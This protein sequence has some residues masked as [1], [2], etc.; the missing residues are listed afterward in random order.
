MF[1]LK[2][3]SCIIFLH[4]IVFSGKGGREGGGGVKDFQ[5]PLISAQEI[6]PDTYLYH[7]FL[8]IYLYTYIY[9][10]IFDS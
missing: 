7:I 10:Y 9:L 1:V 4:V 2:Q 5:V 8:F 6:L 3:M